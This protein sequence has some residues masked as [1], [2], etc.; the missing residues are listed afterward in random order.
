[1]QYFWGS[2]NWGNFRIVDY[3]SKI[4]PYT[5]PIEDE[6]KTHESS[7]YWIPSTDDFPKHL[8]L[9]LPPIINRVTGLIKDLFFLVVKKSR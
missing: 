4:F 2:M 7:S 9:V 5:S 1:M 3:A 6:E 8:R